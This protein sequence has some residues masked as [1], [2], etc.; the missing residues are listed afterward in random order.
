MT[1]ISTAASPKE[2]PGL[3]R[4]LLLWQVADMPESTWRV[5]ITAAQLLFSIFFAFGVALPAVLDDLTL[6]VGFADKG[7]STADLYQRAEAAFMASTWG[8]AIWPVFLFVLALAMAWSAWVVFDGYRRY[9]KAFGYGFPLRLWAGLM[10]CQSVVVGVY[11]LSV[12]LIGGVSYALGM[13]FDAGFNLV[14]QLTLLAQEWSANIPTLVDLPAPIAVVLILLLSDLLFYWFH[15]LGHTWRPFWLL[16]HR[17]HH[18]SPHLITPTAQAVFTAVPLFIVL[19]L[20]Y[21]WLL[22]VSAQLFN[23]EALVMEFILLRLLREFLTVF[24]HN[25]AH[26]S[27][28]RSR[29]WFMRL[30]LFFGAG[31]YHYVHHSAR[32]DDMAVNLGV[33][34][35]LFWDRVFGTYRAP[36]EEKPPVGL[37]N[38][39]ELHLNPFSMALSGML[40]LAYELKHNKELGIRWKILFGPAD[41]AP[42]VSCNFLTVDS[43]ASWAGRSGA[44]Q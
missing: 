44:G 35:G 33:W 8:A 40:Q 17:L 27:M 41:Y 12:G 31:P 2:K 19:A 34:F 39:P 15:R 26:Y 18:V 37:T 22:G 32:R 5:W 1:E 11:S 29:P 7:L 25:S 36:P 16:W 3:W 14:R 30:A 23:G 43:M 9:P 21:Q 6:G 24:D 10:L 20:P 13:G 38:Q 42:P 28:L 4:R